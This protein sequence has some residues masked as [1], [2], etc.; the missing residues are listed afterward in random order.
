MPFDKALYAVK[1]SVSDADALTVNNTKV[2]D[3]NM[4]ASNGIFHVI[5]TVLLP[6]TN[7]PTTAVT[8]A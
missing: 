2:T 3:A 5:E 7:Q 6:P 4:A 1:L 8:A